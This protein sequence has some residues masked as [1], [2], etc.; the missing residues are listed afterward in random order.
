MGTSQHTKCNESIEQHRLPLVSVVLPTYNRPALLPETINSV[1]DQSYERIEL[2]VVD[3]HS[4]YSQRDIVN[5]VSHEGIE[6]VVFVRHD[7]NKGLSAA[8]NTGIEQA[9]G[10]LIAFVDDDDIWMEEKIQRQVDLFLS[11]R[12]D[13]GAICTGVKSINA[14]G[15]VISTWGVVPEGV[16]T[17]DL[18]Y[19]T[20]VAVP[21]LLVRRS[22]IADAGGFDERLRVYEDREWVVRLS[23]H[24]EFRSIPEPLLITQRDDDHDSLTPDLDT[25]KQVSQP[26]LM[27]TFRSIAREYGTLVERKSVAYVTFSLGYIALKQGE[28]SDARQFIGK[29][30]LTWP[31]V[32]K[33]YPYMLGAVLGDNGYKT[34][35][36]MKRTAIQYHNKLAQVY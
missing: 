20:I 33:F 4:T 13:V 35:R 21:T 27:D 23:Q 34:V 22:V 12:D 26:I 5:D 2:I 32:L 31:F 7:D 11:S 8:R 18:L 19:D 14:D 28:K 9:S 30:L 10:E 17:K 3:D 24:C 16:I 29:A 15:D 1:T 25:R 36:K 6:E